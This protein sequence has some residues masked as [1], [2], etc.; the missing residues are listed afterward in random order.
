MAQKRSP[1]KKR[2]NSIAKDLVGKRVL[3]PARVF[4]KEDAHGAPGWEATVLR[5]STDHEGHFEVQF[6]GTVYRPTESSS[7]QCMPSFFLQYH[8]RIIACV[9]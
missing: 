7:L 5:P 4:P 2:R 6:K 9:T 3:V 8:S 1:A